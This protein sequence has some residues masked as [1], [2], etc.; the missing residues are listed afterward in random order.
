MIRVNQLCKKFELSDPAKL[1]QQKQQD[2]RL[3]G[4]FFY[5]LQDVNFQCD[6]G[7]VLGLLGPNGAGKTTTLRILSTALTAN[8]GEIFIDDKNLTFKPHLLREKLGFLSGSTGLYNRLTGRENIAYFGELHGLSKH[9]IGERI[10]TIANELEMHSFLDRRCETY[11]TG[12]KQKTAIARAVIHQPEVVIL[13][14]PTTGLDIMATQTVLAFIERLKQQG[15]AVVFSTHHLDEVQILCDEVCVIHQ[16]RSTFNDNFQAFAA[17]SDESLHK[18]FMH[19]L[20][21]KS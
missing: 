19:C 12:M 14:E 10:A 4:R 17:L 16:G 6:R 9:T 11:S 3:K 5:S 2:P 8:S 15:I 18:A 20:Q 1:Q 21:E 7:Q 13:D